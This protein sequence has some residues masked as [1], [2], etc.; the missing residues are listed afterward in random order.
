MLTE[1]F[2]LLVSLFLVVFCA[3]YLVEGS[4]VIAKKIGIS[5][6]IIGMFIIGF[7]TSMPELVVSLVGAIEGNTDVALGNII[8][9]NIFNTGAILGLGALIAPLAVSVV[10][11][12]RDIP[13]MLMATALFLLL[14]LSGGGI[15]RLEGALLIA[16]F[17]M[18]V[19]YLFKTDGEEKNREIEIK[20][21][22]VYQSLPGSI[23]IVIGSII[24]L[25]AGGHMFV[26]S[27]VKVGTMIGISDKVIGITILGFGTSLPELAACIAAVS[28]KRTQMALGDIIGSNIF[29]ML[30]II[31]TA[32][33]VHPLGFAN[34]T[35]VDLAAFVGCMIIMFISQHTTHKGT[36]TRFDGGC[37]LALFIAYMVMLFK[38]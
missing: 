4:T 8:G 31:G 38:L 28:K 37:L 13:F 25:C 5:E 35:I 23:V 27:A 33:L 36:I 20:S 14:G 16:F 30:L 18:Y 10:N 2:I 17:V 22:L 34:I 6:F 29:N 21:N 15:D 19:F 1:L 24:G 26:D 7:G 3:N 32:S 11:S 9:S 12:K